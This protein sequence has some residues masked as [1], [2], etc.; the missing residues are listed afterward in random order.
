[1][2]GA[3]ADRP[4]AVRATAASCAGSSLG[5]VDLDARRFYVRPGLK[6]LARWAGRFGDRAGA[7]RRT[8]PERPG[9]PGRSGPAD[10]AGATW[11]RQLE[12]RTT[13]AEDF[14]DRLERVRR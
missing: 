4:A 11:R 2:R 5:R 13:K 7:A 6:F 14:D 8:G 9:G 1:S 10:R 3:A 12:R